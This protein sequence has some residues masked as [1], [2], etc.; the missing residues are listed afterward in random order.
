MFGMMDFDLEPTRD[1]SELSILEIAGY[2]GE[3]YGAYDPYIHVAG[4]RLYLV[5]DIYH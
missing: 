5:F 4:D 3:D 2:E 1:T